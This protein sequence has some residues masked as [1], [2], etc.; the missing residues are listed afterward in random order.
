MMP[1][2]TDNPKPGRVMNLAYQPVRA[3]VIERRRCAFAIK[4]ASLAV[5][6]DEPEHG[7]DYQ[8][9]PP[10]DF[11]ALL[12]GA[13]LRPS[14]DLSDYRETEGSLFSME[15]G[16]ILTNVGAPLKI[17][18]KAKVTDTGLYPPSF[19]EALSAWLA[20][21]ASAVPTMPADAGACTPSE[22]RVTLSRVTQARRNPLMRMDGPPVLQVRTT[23]ARGAG[24]SPPSGP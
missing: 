16:K 1:K 6:S 17:I 9:Q 15:N 11:L 23:L 10:T 2:L 3:A 21:T 8:Y 22:T 7:F 12:P 20:A 5:L 19:C 13:D 4:R 24:Y 18:Y 14:A